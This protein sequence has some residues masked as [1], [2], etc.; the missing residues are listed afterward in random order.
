MSFLH[1]ASCNVMMPCRIMWWIPQSSLVHVI[2][3]YMY[4]ALPGTWKHAHCP[5]WYMETCSW[6]FLVLVMALPGTWK[7]AHGPS[8]YMETWSW[9]FL[10]HGNVLMALPGT[11]KHTHG[12]SWYM[13]TYSWPFLVH[14][15]M[16]MA[17]PGTWPFLVQGN[18]LM[19][20]PGTWKHVHGPSWYMAL[21]GTWKHA[22]GPSWYMETCS[23]PFLVHV[24]ISISD[25]VP[26]HQL[27][28][29]SITFQQENLS[30]ISIDV[31]SCSLCG[32]NQ[33]KAQ[34]RVVSL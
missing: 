1:S 17:F 7:H 14:G 25:R 29:H 16:F 12:P 30:L 13:E 23:W 9:P 5:S 32:K 3:K 8:W 31:K 34:R 10:V 19:A 20:L 11:W 22:H 2:I 26:R 27:N 6:P 4:M 24:N 18:I 28:L 15:N 21:P 33:K